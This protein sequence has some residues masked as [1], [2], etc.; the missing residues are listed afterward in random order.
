METDILQ[1][2]KI[3]NALKN[4]VIPDASLHLLSTGRSSELTEFLRCFK[5]IKEGSGEI[6]FLSGEYG[7]GKSF[8]LS[9]V[10]QAAV[11]E[12]FLVSKIMISKGFNLSNME[13]LYY[14]IMHNLSIHAAE[15]AGTDFETIFDIWVNQLQ[16]Y[17]DRN[18]AS[19]EIRNVI[20]SLN[21][22]NSSFARAFLVYVKAKISGD[23][24]LSNAAA[25]WIKGEKNI[26]AH[27]K[28]R[29]DVKGDIDKQNSTDFLKAF[30]SL[31]GLLGY[32]GLI[33]LVDELELAMNLRS[34]IRKNAYE[35]I[36]YIV[37]ESLSGGFGKCMFVFAGTNEVFENDEKGIKTYPALYQRLGNGSGNA[38]AA[39][40][41]LR[42]PVIRL[43][44][45]NLED[46]QELTD[47]IIEHH[48]KAFKWSPKLSNE[49][50][51]N[52]SLLEFKKSRDSIL[53]V[54]TREYITK[55]IEILDILEQNPDNKVYSSELRL[56]KK[57]GIDTF[58]NAAIKK[59]EL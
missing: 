11:E 44:R 26:P 57:N 4:G 20:G 18:K 55:L 56:V 43:K 10:R 32:S 33:I 40:T 50:I 37:D 35:N 31:T 22:F 7:A 25:S 3:I 45:L 59:D 48:V 21:N 6:K 42:K 49:G 52:W 15:S 29:F 14:N 23:A 51:R 41:N 24:E 54:N 5:N 30:I 8:M 36:R 27:V 1:S 53:P 58:V 19:E 38:D 34:D 17:S 47:K 9:L 13:Q 2:K 12:N 16:E 28:S 39:F 46:I